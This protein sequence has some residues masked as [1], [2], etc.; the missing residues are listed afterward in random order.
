VLVIGDG[1]I[2]DEIVLGRRADHA[3]APLI[4]RLAQLGL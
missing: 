4:T 2:K 3:A 1:M